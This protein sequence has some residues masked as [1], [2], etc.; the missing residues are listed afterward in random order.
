MFFERIWLSVEDNL[1]FSSPEAFADRSQH[2]YI[3]RWFK[4]VAGLL[5]YGGHKAFKKVY[6]QG[7][8]HLENRCLRKE[9]GQ[10]VNLPGSW[11]GSTEVNGE[12]VLTYGPS[13]LLRLYNL[14][15]VTK[16]DLTRLAHMVST[17]NL[18]PPRKGD[19]DE[20]LIKH[21]KVLTTLPP[22]VPPERLQ[23]VFFLGLRLGKRVDRKAIAKAVNR[24]EHLSLTNRS[25]FFYGRGDG[26]RAAEVQHEY[27]RW[28]LKDSIAGSIEPIWGPKIIQQGGKPRW[29]DFIHHPLREGEEGTEFLE[30][31]QGQGGYTGIAGLN[32]NTGLQL[33]QCSFEHMVE[34]GIMTPEGEI[35]KELALV[36]TSI[37]G[38][39]GFKSR[40]YTISEWFVTIFL[41]PYGHL[42]V[43]ALETLDSARAGLKAANPAWEW[44]NDFRWKDPKLN[45]TFR[46][47]MLLTSDLETATDYCDH[48]V[49]SELQRGFLAG[50]GL[51]GHRY[52]EAARRLL[53]SPRM[54]ITQR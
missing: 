6:K 15:K 23:V 25:S 35:G 1:L 46:Q 52:L 40:I 27:S 20:A 17:R 10:V 12:M 30:E 34:R 28:A 36:K 38:E 50:L 42:L 24:P 29:K 39:P 21:H 2:W 4:F 9:T 18:P 31:F 22:E 47:L 49:S 11:P 51:S 32:R 53:N 19:G 16:S 8:L 54:L 45:P 5:T 13:W 41:Q 7:L 37:C 26:G 3:L 48:K 14:G 44:S 33:L 43:S